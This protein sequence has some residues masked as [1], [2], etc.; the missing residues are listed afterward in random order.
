MCFRY[1]CLCEVV[2]GTK[3]FCEN[4]HR[5]L[6]EA[7]FVLKLARYHPIKIVCN[8]QLFFERWGGWDVFAEI[9]GESAE[10]KMWQLEPRITGLTLV[11]ICCLRKYGRAFSNWLGNHLEFHSNLGHDGMPH[12]KSLLTTWASMISQSFAT[13]GFRSKGRASSYLAL[14]VRIVAIKD[15][16]KIVAEGDQ[17]LLNPNLTR[18]RTNKRKDFMWDTST[19]ALGP[20]ILWTCPVCLAH[21]CRLSRGHSVQSVRIYRDIRSGLLG[22]IW[23]L[24]PK[25]L[26]GIPRNTDHQIVCFLFIGFVSLSVP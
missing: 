8:I 16:F 11:R 25:L 24:P 19:S 15:P 6:Q 5:R 26:S 20:S 13:G 1:F 4:F 2:V 3:P 22:C 18:G 14:M 17:A 7:D 21:M 23:D 10:N 12:S 9:F